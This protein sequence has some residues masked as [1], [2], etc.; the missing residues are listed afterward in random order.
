[1]STAAV[2]TSMASPPTRTPALP[3]YCPSKCGSI[4]IPY[5]PFGISAECAWLGG[6]NFTIVFNHSFSPPKPYTNG[7]VEIASMSVETGEMHV[8]AWIAFVCYNSSDNIVNS[9]QGQFGL[10]LDPPFLIS[11]TE[12]VFTAIVCDTL[13]LLQGGSNYFTGCISYCASL[14]DSALDEDPCTAL[15]CCQSSIPGNL[16]TPT[17]TP[18][19]IILR[20]ST[21]TP[22]RPQRQGKR[23]LHQSSWRPLVLDW[24]IRANGSCKMGLDTSGVSGKQTAPACASAHSYCH[25]LNAT[26]GG[27][28]LCKCSKG[29]MG[30]PYIINSCTN[31]NECNEVRQ[32]NSTR[33]GP[34]GPNSTCKDTD[35]DYICKCKFNR[36]GDG[37]SEEGCDRYVLSPYAIAAIAIVVL[38]CFAVILLQRRN[39]T[40]LFNKNGGKILAAHGITMYSESQLKNITKDRKLLLGGGKF[41][42]VYEGRIEGTPA[43][44]VAVKYSVVTTM[45]RHWPKTIQQLVQQEQDDDDGGFVNE[46]IF[47]LKIRH[48]N[49]VK[50]IGCCLETNIPIL[51][52][53]FVS[54]GSLEKRLHDGDKR[55]TLSLLKRLDIAIGS[56]EALSH[57]HSHGDHVHGDVKP[58]NILLDDDLN[59]KVSDFGS[60][61]L[62]LLK[63][64]EL[65]AGQSYIDPVYTKTDHFTVKSDVYSF[66]VVLLELITRKKARYD[67]NR[68]LPLD[69]VKCF[70]DEGSG[71][72][73]YYRE[74]F[75]GDDAQSQCYMQCLDRIGM[76]AVRCLKEDLEKRPTM[77]EVV[78]ELKQAKDMACGGSSSS[79]TS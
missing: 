43:Q 19:P 39:R 72:K 42:K 20:G 23:Q 64:K 28:Y 57:I 1:M 18:K 15:G 26:R 14:K 38:A 8:Y 47:Q 70:K 16:R 49:V 78:E 6:G 66:G 46:I 75:S 33:Y 3:D 4:D 22:A 51:V 44:L 79:Q 17:K 21:A 5:Y 60:S 24:A 59:P 55:Y 7:N 37:K 68:S 69:F 40:K 41:G 73:M 13:A 63:T 10:S 12:N 56:A 53:E 25:D 71:R 36:K 2:S 34:C 54:N 32:S 48:I 65:Y 45:G 62:L 31:I 29:Y 61:K 9:D 35:G 50:L 67:G 58:A 27:G 77:A 30:N 11:S 76:L 52:F 74:V